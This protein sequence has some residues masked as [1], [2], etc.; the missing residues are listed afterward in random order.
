MT[1]YVVSASRDSL[2]NRRPFADEE[3]RY[4]NTALSGTRLVTQRTH[5][6]P[7]NPVKEAKTA[8]GGSFNSG[9][10]IVVLVLKSGKA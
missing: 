4:V 9:G 7:A 8:T 3:T 2:A 6:T 1:H 10:R 5:L